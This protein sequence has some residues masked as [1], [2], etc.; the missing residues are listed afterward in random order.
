MQPVQLQTEYQPTAT[1][2]SSNARVSAPDTVSTTV[3][4]NN[5]DDGLTNANTSVRKFHNASQYK[6]KP[7]STTVRMSDKDFD[8]GLTTSVRNV[9][10]AS[11]NKGIQP[12]ADKQFPRDTSND[13]NTRT[14]RVKFIT[15]RFIQE[16]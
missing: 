12:E 1:A 11:Q 10:K 5:S 13:A 7:V 16:Y 8:D 6:G 9:L 15:K 3:H 2:K 14:K 4:M